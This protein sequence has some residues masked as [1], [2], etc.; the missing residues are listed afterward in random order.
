M[1]GSRYERTS[2]YSNRCNNGNIVII[3]IAVGFGHAIVVPARLVA[4]A[5]QTD[6]QGSGRR[7]TFRG[8]AV[9]KTEDKTRARARRPTIDVVRSNRAQTLY[10]PRYIFF[11]PFLH[12]AHV[13]MIF[14]TI[15]LF[16][17]A[18]RVNNVPPSIHSN[19]TRF[20]FSPCT[21]IEQITRKNARRSGQ[22]IPVQVCGI[23]DL[24]V[25]AARRFI[26]YTRTRKNRVMYTTTVDFFVA[27]GYCD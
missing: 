17:D 9:A 6:L 7:Q 1:T 13:N 4:W 24:Q 15:I 22:A 25:Y 16:V 3:V 23:T 8:I 10:A 18:L 20:L 21:N 14:A 19:H 2:E 26:I 27:R 12:R 11:P 5:G